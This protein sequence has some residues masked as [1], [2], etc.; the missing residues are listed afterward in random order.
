MTA[1]SAV[2][3]ALWALLAGVV[4][5][6]TA[7][8]LG[9]FPGAQKGTVSGT[10]TLGAPFTLTA[11]TGEPYSWE[12]ATGAPHAIFFGFTFCPDVCPTTLYEMTTWLDR[13]GSDGETIK[14][15]FISVDPERDT[16]EKLA[17]Y[18]SAFDERIVGLTGSQADIDKVAGDF[19]I[20]HKRVELDD[21]D[22]T[23][24]HTASVL[25][26]K[27]DGSF[28]GTIAYGEDADSAVDKLRRLARS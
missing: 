28:F 24:D 18:L 10:A 26:F 8:A 13:L 2:R 17:N 9:L 3:Y 23:M 11:M 25:L 15:L 14:A 16:P 6:V 21:G 27:P 5:G 1:L 22:Y 20:Y 4:I 12:P 19:R 7:A